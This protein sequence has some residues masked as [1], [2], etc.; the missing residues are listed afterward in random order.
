M[1]RYSETFIASPP[2]AL[3]TVH[4]R[5]SRTPKTILLIEDNVIVLTCVG[6]ALADAGFEVFEAANAYEA[7]SI[8]KLEHDHIGMICTD[9]QMPGVMNG[10]G[11]AHQA[12]REWPWIKLLIVS[13]QPRDTLEDLPAETVFLRKLCDSF[14]LVQQISQTLNDR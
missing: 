5:G 3:M 8:L 9:I 2:S 12:R 6:E 1:C 14:D 4:A 10:V 13:G 11:L 7:L